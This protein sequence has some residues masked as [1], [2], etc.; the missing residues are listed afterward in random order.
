MN[1]YGAPG[2]WETIL[3]TEEAGSDTAQTETDDLD[4]KFST[5]ALSRAA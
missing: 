2:S 3:A 1:E 4:Q 5:C